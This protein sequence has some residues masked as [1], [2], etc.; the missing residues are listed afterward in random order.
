MIAA[1]YVA[2]GGCYYGLPDVDPWD[3]ER[4]ARLYAGPWPVVAHPPCARWS[5]L[6][7]LVEAVHGHKRGDD[8][9]CFASALA[10]VRRYGGVLEHPA[11][12][13]AWK[14]A[15]LN[16]PPMSG[17]WV[18]A[19]WEGGWTCCVSQV[20]YGH[21]ARKRTWL[22]AKGCELPSFKWGDGPDAGIVHDSGR[23]PS[24]P[25][26]H[27]CRVLEF[28]GRKSRHPHP[29]PRPAPRHG[30]DRH[31]EIARAYFRGCPPAHPYVA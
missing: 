14:A 27:A 24:R 8:G 1:L 29:L 4:D 6:A 15:R 2:K 3:E 9:G 22:Y 26:A 10:A 30:A 20:N 19:D 7:A 23:R 12:T 17:A 28:Q 13:G 25:K 16:K 5:T 18:N 21:R 31:S 11:Q